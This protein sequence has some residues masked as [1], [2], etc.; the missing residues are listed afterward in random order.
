[1]VVKGDREIKAG[2]SSESKQFN[3]EITLPDF[4][5][6]TSVTSY[7]TDGVLIVEAP[8]QL[9]RLGYTPAAAVTNSSTSSSSSS[10]QQSSNLRNSPYRDTQS[11]SRVNLQSSSSSQSSNTQQR[12]NAYGQ[13]SSSTGAATGASP[14]YSSINEP[15]FTSSVSPAVSTGGAPLTVYKF[16]MSEFRPEDIAITVTDTTLKVH[17]VREESDPRGAEKTY[18]EFK[19]EVGLP[20]GADVK[21]FV[22]IAL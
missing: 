12:N 20:H 6:P 8:V 5:E 14:F 9:D 13:Q 11:P 15:S 10:Q 1:M 16:N 17:A 2:G 21:R 4:I 7:L 19:R 18:R 3:R 22:F